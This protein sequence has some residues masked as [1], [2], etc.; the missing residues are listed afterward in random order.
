MTRPEVQAALDRLADEREGIRGRDVVAPENPGRASREAR[1]LEIEAEVAAIEAAV[2]PEPPPVRVT[3][4][5]VPERASLSSQITGSVIAQ[6]DGD[7]NVAVAEVRT[8]GEVVARIIA[9]VEVPCPP[10]PHS[11]PAITPA[12]VFSERGVPPPQIEPGETWR[13]S[14]SVSFIAPRSPPALIYRIGASV[15]FTDGTVVEAEPVRMR[16]NPPA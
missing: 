15:R 6:N 8:W 14:F 10:S 5:G 3:L 4:S 9:E 7:L 2:E 12:A 1:L 16:V 11:S 13:W